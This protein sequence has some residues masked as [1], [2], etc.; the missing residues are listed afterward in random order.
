MFYYWFLMQALLFTCSFSARNFIERSSYL[1]IYGI[2]DNK[3]LSLFFSMISMNKIRRMQEKS[4]KEEGSI[5]YTP[6]LYVSTKNQDLRDQISER[7]VSLFFSYVVEREKNCRAGW[8]CSQ[9][10]G[11]CCSYGVKPILLIQ[12]GL[13][14]IE[15]FNLINMPKDRRHWFGSL[16]LVFLLFVDVNEYLVN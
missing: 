12:L 1:R 15:T 10:R 2:Y 5:C 8:M 4:W 3:C 11:W 16:F 7:D 13:P 14:L 6:F 9:S